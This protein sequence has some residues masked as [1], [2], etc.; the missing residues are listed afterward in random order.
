MDNALSW[1]GREHAD[2]MEGR[3]SI[4]D[5]GEDAAQPK[6]HPQIPDGE[7]EKSELLALEKESLGIYVSEH[8]LSGVK[9]QLARKTDCRLSEISARRDGEIVT[10]GGMVGALKQLTTRRVTMVF[11]RSKKSRSAEIVVFNSVYAASR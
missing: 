8:P 10:V 5:L 6:V 1:G 3:L 11:V 2:R 7:F 4:F 9:D